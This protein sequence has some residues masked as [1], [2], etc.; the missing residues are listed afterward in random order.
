MAGVPCYG[1]PMKRLVEVQINSL[2][3]TSLAKALRDG[4]GSVAACEV[5]FRKLSSVLLLT[6]NNHDAMSFSIPKDV[7]MDKLDR[8]TSIIVILGF[9]NRLLN[10]NELVAGSTEM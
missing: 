7:I 2:P 6:C 5:F 10:R 3:K 4:D 8:Y 9:Y 1:D